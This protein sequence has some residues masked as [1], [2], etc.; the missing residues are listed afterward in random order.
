MVTPVE[1]GP[2]GT[3]LGERQQ[4]EE[5]ANF[6]EINSLDVIMEC[7]RGCPVSSGVAWQ[8]VQQ[9]LSASFAR[10]NRSPSPRTLSVFQIPLLTC[11]F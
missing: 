3:A 7:P 1:R 9:S 10:S 6:R 5:R 2:T 4:K 11:P 8:P